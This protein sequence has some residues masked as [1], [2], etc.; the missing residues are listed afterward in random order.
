LDLSFQLRLRGIKLPS[1]NAETVSLSDHKSME[2]MG[3]ALW[4]LVNVVAKSKNNHGPIVFAKWDIK[5]GFWQLVVSEEDSWNFCY[6]L[7]RI[8]E[9]DPMEIV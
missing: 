5:D 7:L 9:D 3:K 8:N 2:Q 6:V 4:C 1:I